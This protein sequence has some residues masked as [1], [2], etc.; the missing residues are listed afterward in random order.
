MNKEEEACNAPGWYCTT[1]ITETSYKLL[2]CP[3]QLCPTEGA[4]THEA[5]EM[6]QEV[7]HSKNWNLKSDPGRHCKMVISASEKLNGKLIVN[8]K[9][10]DDAEVH[11][12]MMPK[13]FNKDYGYV[14]LF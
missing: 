10:V 12:F 13:H 4:Y 3:Q 2:T 9:S 7:L 14:G 8:L 1:G 5:T 6:N 11:I